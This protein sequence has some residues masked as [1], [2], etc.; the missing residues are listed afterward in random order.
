MTC[1]HCVELVG[2]TLW[3]FLLARFSSLEVELR[4]GGHA[5]ICCV[6]VELL[7]QEDSVR[8]AFNTLV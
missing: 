3:D 2:G 4:C 6:A 8:K 1:K 5:E 7:C